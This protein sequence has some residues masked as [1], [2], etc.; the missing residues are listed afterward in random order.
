MKRKFINR[1]IIFILIMFILNIMFINVNAEGTKLSLNCTTN[2]VLVLNSISC[3]VNIETDVNVNNISFTIEKDGLDITFMEA[4]DFT[5][6]STSNG[7]SL[8]KE[9]ITSGKI[10]TLEI[11]APGNI[12]EGAKT[13]VLKNIIISNSD[14][15]TISFNG[16]DVV[17]TINVI[18]N[19]SN[20][21]YLK[22]LTIDDK[23]ITGFNK[24]KEEYNITVNTNK[25]TIGASSEHEKAQVDGVGEKT[26]AVGK[27]EYSITVTAEN[28]TLKTY[29]INITYEIPKSSDNTLKTLELYYSDEKIDFTYDKTKTEFDINV[30][31][32]IDKL[33]IKSSLNDEKAR[34]V[35]KYE[36][37]DVEL[38]YGKNRFEIRILAENNDVK[39]YFLNIV[40]E[41][42]RNS[43]KT[44]SELIINDE[45]VSLSSS[46]FEYRVDV[47]YKYIRSD[48]KATATDEKAKVS[49]TNI[50]LAD[51]ENGPII[52][53]VTAEN[54][55][56]QEY[57][58]VIN[59]L[60][61]AESK[62]VL[63]NITIDGYDFPFDVNV[64]NYNLKL[65]GNEK[66]LKIKVSP[67]ENL[68]YVILNNENLGNGSTVIIR[69]T[70]DDGEKSY[71]INIQKDVDEIFG[72]PTNIFCYGVFGFGVI[73]LIGSIIYVVI[74]N[75]KRRSK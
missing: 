68:E 22:D 16:A 10:G 39:S 26:L 52:I 6:N 63:Q 12:S 51:G 61:E 2:E 23:T 30:E 21:N 17:E 25:I 14:D 29:R 28:G 47:R 20:N 55:E 13:I 31:A 43:N 34:Y 56:V 1:I 60:S 45:K 24:D 71:T 59:R 73:S 46:I 75:K 38:K 67:E 58:I 8:H 66:A 33:T 44:L 40:R 9:N 41:D 62:V 49:F 7:I 36:N 48:I 54:G 64:R 3:H 19:K 18:S 70:D 65:I 69:V 57:K 35:K 50:D 32:G 42:D 4:T 5:N 53:T 15:D 72:I 37:R 11:N 27:N 74:E